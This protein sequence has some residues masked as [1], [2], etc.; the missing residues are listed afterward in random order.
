[1]ASDGRIHEGSSPDED[2]QGLA[3]QA[4]T[5]TLS[6]EAVSTGPESLENDALV[7]VAGEG[8]DAEA[9]TSP[10]QVRTEVEPAHP[11]QPEA[12][13]DHLRVVPGQTFQSLFGA[14]GLTQHAE[15]RIAAEDTNE[16]L[17]NNRVIVH[18]KDRDHDGSARGIRASTVTP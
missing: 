13:G 14:A 9:W 16:T 4:R 6:N 15:I 11:R 18:D 7:A 2:P 1:M 10:G 3:E 8:Q 5:R 12:Q 17:P